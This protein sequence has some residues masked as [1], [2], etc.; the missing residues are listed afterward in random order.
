M[1]VSSYTYI[2]HHRIEIRE[3]FAKAKEWIGAL[4]ASVSMEHMKVSP[5]FRE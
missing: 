5:G 1:W 4:F 2:F 3:T